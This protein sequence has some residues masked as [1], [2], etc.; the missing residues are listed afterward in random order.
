MPQKA[1]KRRPGGV[2]ENATRS[3]QMDSQCPTPELGA[4]AAASCA[5][6]PASLPA[7]VGAVEFPSSPQ[8]PLPTDKPQTA[9]RLEIEWPGSDPDTAR[10]AILPLKKK[11]THAARVPQIFRP[12]SSFVETELTVKSLRQMTQERTGQTVT[13][14]QDPIQTVPESRVAVKV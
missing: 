12:F 11:P 8:V 1:E 4:A 14:C 5:A 2:F 9:F 3:R 7:P 10:W 6:L 13:D